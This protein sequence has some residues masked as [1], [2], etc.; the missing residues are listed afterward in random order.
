MF[1]VAARVHIA[2]LLQALAVQHEDRGTQAVRR[3]KVPLIKFQG[4]GKPALIARKEQKALKAGRKRVD[5]FR[6]RPARAE[7][8]REHPHESGLQFA[9]RIKEKL[10]AAKAEPQKRVQP[11]FD[12]GRIQA[13]R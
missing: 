13:G 11:V 12:A 4:I 2:G 9:D 5:A 3:L 10:E 1:I 7:L 8:F 6:R